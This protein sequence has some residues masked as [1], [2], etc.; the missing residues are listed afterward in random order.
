MDPARVQNRTGSQQQADHRLHSARGGALGVQLG[1]RPQAGEP[2][3]P[4]ARVSQPRNAAPCELN[5]V[6]PTGSCTLA[7]SGLQ[8]RA[9]RGVYAIWTPPSRTT[10]P[11][12]PAGAK[13]KLHGKIGYPQRK[14]QR[15]WAGEQFSAS[16]ARL[17]VLPDAIQLPRLRQLRL[18][19]RSLPANHGQEIP[20]GHRQ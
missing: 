6:R 20:L 14:T 17:S 16:P 4:R 19:E 11:R 12:A 5:T 2:I 8:V 7:V 15:A 13:G 9:P 10:S 18:K 1:T 3:T